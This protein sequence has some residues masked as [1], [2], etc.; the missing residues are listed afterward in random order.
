[1][2][3]ISDVISFACGKV[4]AKG[5][6]DELYAANPDLVPELRHAR[7]CGNAEAYAFE[8]LKRATLE[9][10]LFRWVHWDCGNPYMIGEELKHEA[11]WKYGWP[12]LARKPVQ[13]A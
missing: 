3:Q 9:P 8:A 10:D 7:N 11:R 12:I 1:M 5:I 13:G 4:I 2:S 6:D